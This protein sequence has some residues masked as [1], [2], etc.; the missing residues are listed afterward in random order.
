MKKEE[1][2][3]IQNDLMRVV[4]LVPGGTAIIAAVNSDAYV[5]TA[6]TLYAGLKK[7]ARTRCEPF[8]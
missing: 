4:A 3:K 8:F 6:F 7:K 5:L 2:S 1:N